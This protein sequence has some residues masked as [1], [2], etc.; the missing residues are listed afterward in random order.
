VDA[1]LDAGV[2]Q[3]RAQLVPSSRLHHEQVVDMVR[4]GRL[5]LEGDVADAGEASTVALGVPVARLVPSGELAQ[6]DGQD[7][8][9]QRVQPG[10]GPLLDVVVLRLLAVVPQPPDPVREPSV[11]GGDHPGV[12]A[13]AEVL[14]RVEAEAPE[15]AHGAAGPAP[16]RR[17]VRLCRVLH[18]VQAV[19][20][21][22]VEDR[23]HVGCLAGEVHRDDRLGPR[24]DGRTDLAAVDQVGARVAVDQDRPGADRAHRQGGGDIG[25]RRQDHLVPWNDV[26][27]G[28]RQPER[29]QARADTDGMADADELGEGTLELADLR[30]EDEPRFVEDVLDGGLRLGHDGALLGGRVEERHAEG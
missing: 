30:A 12:A 6:P 15:R 9:L 24:R 7:G 17:A 27:C 28:Q 10:V 25:V 14:A 11:T 5:V 16:V 3:V 19:G 18:H 23:V 8:R 26:E 2:V 13:R 4:S 20:T 22:E 1:G 21:R 29:V